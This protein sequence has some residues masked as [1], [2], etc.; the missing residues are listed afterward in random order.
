MRFNLLMVLLKKSLVLCTLDM[1]VTLEVIVK[2]H[3]FFSFGNGTIEFVVF[4]SRPNG[5]IIT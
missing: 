5:I 4:Q 2:G 1:N 3:Q